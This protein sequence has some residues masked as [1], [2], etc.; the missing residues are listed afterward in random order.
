MPDEDTTSCF[1]I[2]GCLSLATH[3]SDIF[4]IKMEEMESAKPNTLLQTDQ[5]GENYHFFHLLHF[6]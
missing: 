3:P 4:L 2:E 5:D 6:Y 1:V